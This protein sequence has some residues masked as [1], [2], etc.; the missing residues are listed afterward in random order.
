MKVPF[1]DLE[2]QYNKIKPEVLKAI[3]DVLDTRQFIQ[4]SICEDFSK[5]FLEIHGGNY[6]VGCS[7][8]TSAITISLRALDIKPGDEVITV[9]NTFFACK[10]I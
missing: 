6:G 1:L 8:G 7:N 4:G 9:A 10:H 3:E 2:A 5:K